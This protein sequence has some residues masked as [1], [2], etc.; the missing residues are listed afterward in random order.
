MKALVLV[1]FIIGMTALLFSVFARPVLLLV[2]GEHVPELVPVLR[3]MV[4]ALCP[5]S[6]VYLIMN[7]ELAQRRFG[8]AIPLLICAVAYVVGVTAWHESLMQVVAILGGVSILALAGSMA[9][10]PWRSIVRGV[11][12]DGT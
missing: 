7:F 6:I 8:T 12:T 11:S 1:G 10:L 9:C 2:T 4:W 3:T 5:L